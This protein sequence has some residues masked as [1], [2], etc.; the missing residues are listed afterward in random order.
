MFIK[1]LLEE[2]EKREKVHDH[3]IFQW[4]WGEDCVKCEDGTNK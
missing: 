2:R 1:I 4:Q 3:Y